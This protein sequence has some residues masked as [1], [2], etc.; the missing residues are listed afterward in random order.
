[1]FSQSSRSGSQNSGWRETCVTVRI[2]AWCSTFQPVNLLHPPTLS[3]RVFGLTD[4]EKVL[5]MDA[6]LL[7]IW[8]VLEVNGC[9]AKG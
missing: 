8:L 9:K 1:M 2:D 6:D 3:C 4:Y 7:V 5:L